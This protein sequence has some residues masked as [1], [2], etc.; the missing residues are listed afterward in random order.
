MTA[1]LTAQSTVQCKHFGTVLVQGSTKLT[2]SSA[3]VLLE[4]G[5]VQPLVPLSCT[6]PIPPQ[7]NVKC[8]NVHQVLPPSL[9]TTLTVG[10]KPVALATLTGTTDGTLACIHPQ[11]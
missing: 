3:G 2:V 7:A 4:D 8:M 5:I 9:A 1:V 10:G 6:I 11:P